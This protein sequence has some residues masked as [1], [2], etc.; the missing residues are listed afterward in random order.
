MNS[1]DYVDA[2]NLA[3]LRIA[4]STLKNVLL[5]GKSDQA[6]V[7]EAVTNIHWIITALEKKVRQGEVYRQD[8]HANASLPAVVG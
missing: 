8:D 6:L 5:L 1:L 7:D 2:T 4:V 3:K